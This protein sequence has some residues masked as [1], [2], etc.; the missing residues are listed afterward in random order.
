[1][2]DVSNIFDPSLNLPYAL[3]RELDFL[4]SPLRKTK[5]GKNVIKITGYHF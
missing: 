1:M 2:I 3:G 5:R 4:V